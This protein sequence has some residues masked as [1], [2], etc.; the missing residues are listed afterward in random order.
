MDF[1]TK[2]QRSQLMAKVRSKGNRKTEL[3]LIV[4]FRAEKIRGWRRNYPLFG[5]PDFVFPQKRI[6]LFGF[7]P[8]LCGYE[9]KSS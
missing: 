5:K 2:Q 8:D 3:R 6:A 1:L 4:L 9:L 7:F